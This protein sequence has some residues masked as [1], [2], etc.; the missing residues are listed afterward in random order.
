MIFICNL[1]CRDIGGAIVCSMFEKVGM[2]R[3]RSSPPVI[4]KSRRSVSIGRR[5]K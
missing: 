3:E 1:S 4:D 5:K 2:A